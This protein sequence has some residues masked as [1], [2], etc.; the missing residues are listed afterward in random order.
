MTLDLELL[1]NSIAQILASEEDELRVLANNAG[2]DPKTDFRGANFQDLDL[3]SQDLSGFDLSE[4]NLSN[5]NLSN[6][7]LSRSILVNACLKGAN[8]T[9]TNFQRANIKGANFEGA[10]VTDADFRNVDT[11]GTNLTGLV[12]RVTHANVANVTAIAELKDSKSTIGMTDFIK[13]IGDETGLSR[14]QI[15]S[16]LD[17]L[18]GVIKKNLVRKNTTAVTIPGLVKIEVVSKAA[19]KPHK[20]FNPFTG[21]EMLYKAKPSRRVVKVRPLKNLN[22]LV[23]K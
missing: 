13:S 14:K 15:E 10:N 4:A 11:T 5:T 2:L 21:E 19:T 7:N 3:N 17:A 9:G 20:G 1:N 23:N 22:D 6:V 18:S 12:K 16:V 8:I